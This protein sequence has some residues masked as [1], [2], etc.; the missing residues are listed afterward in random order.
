MFIFF[1]TILICAFIAST[2]R[3][4]L[5]DVIRFKKITKKNFTPVIM[6]SIVLIPMIY[7]NTFHS[8]RIFTSAE[9]LIEFA[10]RYDDEELYYEGVESLAQDDSSDVLEQLSFAHF[11]FEDFY[12]NFSCNV[13]RDRY[14]EYDTYA[15]KLAGI[16]V[17]LRC[18]P[19]N[20]QSSEIEQLKQTE[21][22]TYFILGMYE[23]YNGNLEKSL[24]YYDAQIVR[25]PDFN[26][27][28]KRKSILLRKIDDERLRDF[29]VSQASHDFLSFHEKN[30]YYYLNGLWSSYFTNILLDRIVNTPWL[31][32]IIAFVVSFV[33]IAYLR[34]MDF[35]NREKWADLLLVF[36]L[37]GIFTIFCLPIYDFFFYDV[38]FY[39]D[40]SAWND[41]WYCTIVIGGA[42]ELVKFIPWL[43][44]GFVFGRF[45]EPFDYILYASMSALGFACLENFS[46]LQDFT[47]ITSRTI[48]STVAHMFDAVIIAY[49]FIIVNYR[50]KKASLIKKIGVILSGFLLAMFAHGFY[51]FWLISPS[52]ADFTLVTLI[53]FV[54]SLHIWFFLKRNAMNHSPFFKGNERFNLTKQKEVLHLGIISVLMLQYVVMGLDYGTERINYFFYKE[55]GY[56]GVFLFYMTGQLNR[57]KLVKGVWNKFSFKEIL[58]IKLIGNIA[59]NISNYA[60]NRQDSFSNKQKRSSYYD[61]PDLRG[62]KLRLFAPKSNKFIGN[63]LPVTGY[64]SKRMV[65]NNQQDWFLFRLDQPVYF[66]SFLSDQILIKSKNDQYSLLDD[67]IEIY[68]MFIPSPDLLQKDHLMISDLR[69]AGKS[70]SRPLNKNE[71]DR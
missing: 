32:M 2:Y 55:A 46:Y 62:L 66:N 52:V 28:Y 60:F 38:Q 18:N 36:V 45:K 19:G 22:G 5:A 21:K 39:L 37:G 14:K 8:T 10:E 1:V 42:E 68:F 7:M 56:A 6:L 50:L 61:G 24:E 27:T 57:F 51:D 20:V 63:Q 30:Q 16:Y 15:G 64:C 40:G 3:Y 12:G 71:L 33:W 49:A 17:K 65:V 9:E 23:E 54:L 35:Y 69:Y 67:K 47:N 11:Y 48:I 53:F 44:F 70:Y 59:Q 29:M 4:S 43:L 13:A 26:L 25:S 34:L 31:V 41:F 58:P